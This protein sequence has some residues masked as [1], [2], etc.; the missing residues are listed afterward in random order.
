MKHSSFRVAGAGV[1]VFALT[2][3]VTGAD[4]VN[5]RPIV[6]L[7]VSLKAGAAS[8]DVKAQGTCTHAPRAGIY[9][10]L[11]EQWMVRQEEDNRSVQLV[12]WKPA[13]GSAPMF[14][15]S[16]NGKTNMSVSTVRGGQVSGGG[17]VTFEPSGKGGTFTVDAKAKSGETITGTLKCEAFTR[18]VSEG[19]D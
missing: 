11:S 7:E 4:Q 8:Y 2:A 19:G 5:R 3:A 15:L 10:V 6:P 16:L 18:A 13:D 9:G 17:T 1:I 14:S 12:F